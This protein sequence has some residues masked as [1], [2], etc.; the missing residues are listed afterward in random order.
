MG[1]T[2]TEN[3][4]ELSIGDE[5]VLE[6]RKGQLVFASPAA[7]QYFAKMKVELGQ[8]QLKRHEF[9]ARALDLKNGKWSVGVSVKVYVSFNGQE[10]EQ[11]IRL[12]TDE[13]WEPHAPHAPIDL[14]KDETTKSICIE[15]SEVVCQNISAFW[16]QDSDPEEM[17]LKQVKETLYSDIKAAND[18]VMN[19]IVQLIMTDDLKNTAHLVYEDFVRQKVHAAINKYSGIGPEALHRFVDELYCKKVHDD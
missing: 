12:S 16:K 2:S 11:Q 8:S 9:S 14:A 10:Y 4:Y 17:V 18:R 15:I 13:K 6:S 7:K 1:F 3:V 5:K 19:D